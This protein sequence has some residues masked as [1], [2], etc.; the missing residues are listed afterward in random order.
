M[1]YRFQSISNTQNSFFQHFITSLLRQ[2]SSVL[3]KQGL[4][5][6]EIP[7]SGWGTYTKNN[8][9]EKSQKRYLQRPMEYGAFG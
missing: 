4:C 1:P 2:A 3:S 8:H 5:P 9:S 7:T 6:S